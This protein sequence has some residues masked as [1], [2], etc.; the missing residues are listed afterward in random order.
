VISLFSKEK[1]GCL[2]DT[3]SW[4]TSVYKNPFQSLVYGLKTS[5]EGRVLQ[6]RIGKCSSRHGLQLEEL[7]QPGD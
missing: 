3:Q 7:L 2:L 6:R 5:P 4:R 1:A